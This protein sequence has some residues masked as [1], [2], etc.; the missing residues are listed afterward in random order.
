M[1]AVHLLN[2][3][4]T[5]SLEG[6]TPYEAWHRRTPSVGHLCPFGCLA[7]LKELNHVGK[8]HDQSS[9]SV[10][11]GYTEGAKAYRILDPMTRRVRTSRDVVFDE[12]QG[13]NWAKNI[14]GN[15]TTMSSEF[16][17]EY[18]QLPRA[19]E[20]CGNAASSASTTPPASPSSGL[21]RVRR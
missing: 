18:V 9:P 10:F 19:E 21:H 15:T 13:W 2:C 20:A 6:K 12:G 17:I 14:D 3:S 8:L 16:T 7:Y 4:P 11:I 5:K 1:T